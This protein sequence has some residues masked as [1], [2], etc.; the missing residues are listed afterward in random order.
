MVPGRDAV[1]CWHGH[2][3][4]PLYATARGK[5][6]IDVP[7]A[8]FTVFGIGFAA[9]TLKNLLTRKPGQQ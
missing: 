1:P 7:T 6:E 8:A 5:V 4:D 2:A 3:A 9:D